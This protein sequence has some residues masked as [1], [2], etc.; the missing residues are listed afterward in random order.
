MLL[1]QGEALRS[2]TDP[3]SQGLVAGIIAS[4]FVMLALEKAHRVLVIFCAVALLWLFTYLTPYKLISFDGAR[5]AL[6]LNVLLLLAAMMA[7]VGVLKSTGVFPWAV[8]RLLRKSGGRPRVIQAMIAWFTGTVSAFADNV[9]TVIFV[10]PMSGAMARLTQVRPAAYLLPM[11]MAANIGGTATLIGDPPNIMI[12]SGANL[13]FMDFIRELTVP[14]LWMML[15]LEVFSRWYYRNEFAPSASTVAPSFDEPDILDPV[16][17]RWSLGITVLIFL[18]FVTHSITHMPVAV[19]AV[20]GAAAVLVVQD[21]LYLRRNRPTHTE[22]QHGLIQIIEREIE[23]PTL[24]FFAFLFIAVGAAV[25]TGLIDTMANGLNAV[26]NAGRES[27]GLTD[28]GTVLFAALMIL[29]VSGIL[30][31]LIDNIPYVAV[32][33]PIVARL[34]ASLPGQPG[35]LWWALALGACLGGNGSL[36]GASANVTT[37]GLAEKEGIRISFREFTRF[38]ATVATLT[39]VVSSIFLAGDI[40]IGD[41]TMFWGGLAGFV[42]VMMARVALAGR[43][44]GG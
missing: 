44:V 10:T 3:V 35:I 22:R 29:W 16:L 19:P 17:L 15:M 5:E 28:R 32:S 14:V 40:Y 34:I 23:W 41:A 25:N 20:I 26:I 8:G 42:V 36:I 39:L 24:C 4:V 18:G 6:D 1:A 30:S 21:V 38:G 33:I 9:T 27:L 37:V 2:T 7:V 11:V 43:R 12:G 31:A 13:A